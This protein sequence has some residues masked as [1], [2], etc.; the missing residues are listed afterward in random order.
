[1]DS[2]Q[3]TYPIESIMIYLWSLSMF[4]KMQYIVERKR[5]A[6]ILGF[7][8]HTFDVKDVNGNLLGCFKRQR[9]FFGGGE[10]WIE[11]TDGR[12][13]GEIRAQ[14]IGYTVYDAQNQLQG[15]IRTDP[16]KRKGGGSFLWGLILAFA[17]VSA[18]F[19][20]MI[21]IAI[22]LPNISPYLLVA[23][24]VSG[25]AFTV[26]GLIRFGYMATKGRFGKPKWLIEDPEGRK[27]AEG[28]DFYL[29]SHVEIL[30]PDEEV[31]ARIEGVII[32]MKPSYHVHIS[33][34]DL[35]SLLILGYTVVMAYRHL[36][37][38]RSA[39]QTM[40]F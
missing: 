11:D 29:D 23:I 40:P 10:F 34:Q 3:Q 25:F 14:K 4:D 5:L 2:K 39:T 7:V 27:L 13:L 28:N 36:E 15:T 30:A 1:M 17:P 20:G 24:L 18:A 21:L 19:F 12:R 16:T 33:R 31:I 26:F 37:A 38:V 9:R 6:A 35:D 8:R 32:S 22:A